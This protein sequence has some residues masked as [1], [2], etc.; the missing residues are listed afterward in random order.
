MDR[1]CKD[2]DRQILRGYRW[3]DV[4]RMMVRIYA[5]RTV[6]D[7][8]FRD[9]TVYIWRIMLDIYLEDNVTYVFRGY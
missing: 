6:R 8:Y 5:A 2:T 4:T 3:T 7:V 9:N 1:Y